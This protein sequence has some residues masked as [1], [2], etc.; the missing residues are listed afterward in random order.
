MN[1][2]TTV[3]TISMLLLA[4]CSGQ[5]LPAAQVPA[6]V[7]GQSG[8]SVEADQVATAPAWKRQ[9]LAER[10]AVAAGL[11]EGGVAAERHQHFKVHVLD[12]WAAAFDTSTP[13]GCAVSSVRSAVAAGTSACVVIMLQK[14]DDGS[15]SV[16]AMGTP[17]SLQGAED[18]PWTL[19]N[20]AELIDLQ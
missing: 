8:P 3:V 6:Q 18:L 7:E 16:K 15:W 17:G 5:S 20:P 12:Q 14:A 19:G 2:R 13:P 9:A 11:V 4:A 10:D 1:I